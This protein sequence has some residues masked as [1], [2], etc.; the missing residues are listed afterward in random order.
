M[1][2]S[3]SNETVSKVDIHGAFK[4]NA[5]TIRLDSSEDYFISSKL[6]ALVWEEMK[7]FCWKLLSN[8]HPASLK[9]LEEVMI[10]PDG[11]KYKLKKVVDGTPP[12][13]ELEIIG[14]E[15]IDEEWDDMENEQEENKLD[16]NGSGNMI[17]VHHVE[18]YENVDE[19]EAAGY[20]ADAAAS[21]SVQ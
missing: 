20:Q 12:D 14:R 13:E 1:C 17:V 9:K 5:I 2:K 11:V 21:S 3:A 8:L 10:T 7:E 4:R 18:E 15:L 16:E 19:L 6:K